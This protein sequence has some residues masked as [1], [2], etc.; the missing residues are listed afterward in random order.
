VV[1]IDPVFAEAVNLDVGYHVFL[2]AYG[3]ADLFV[4]SRTPTGFEVKAR[5]AAAD[6]EFS[7]RLVA[8]RSGFEDARLELAP[9][10]GDA[11]YAE[12]LLEM[13]AEKASDFEDLEAADPGFFDGLAKPEAAGPDLSEDFEQSEA[14]D[15][16]ALSKPEA[17]APDGAEDL[18]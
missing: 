6:V 14:A 15:Q 9:W 5:G 10:V 7:Y 18:R 16:E 3:D 4:S 8:K 12:K 13:A 1:A 17:A 11:L 2:Q